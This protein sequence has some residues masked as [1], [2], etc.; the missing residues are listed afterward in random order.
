MPESTQQADLMG[1]TGFMMLPQ[2]QTWLLQ[3]A[4]A[5]VPGPTW[6]S[7]AFSS[8][9][10]RACPVWTCA[11]G[12]LPSARGGC[13]LWWPVLHLEL[14]SATYYAKWRYLSQPMRLGPGPC[15]SHALPLSVAIKK[16]S[17]SDLFGNASHNAQQ[18]HLLPFY[19]WPDVF[20]AIAW[21]TSSPTVPVLKSCL[22][23][24]SCI[25]CEW[26]LSKDLCIKHS[27]HGTSLR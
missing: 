12:F 10:C 7:R 2:G 1:H 3:T 19:F 15:P 22:P 24:S 27:L 23:Q 21:A 6:P 16:L 17:P 4:V 8:A 26:M 13:I 18:W 20:S 9:T 5:G 11:R 14:R 25:V